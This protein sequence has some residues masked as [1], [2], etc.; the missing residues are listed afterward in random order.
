MNYFSF[1]FKLVILG[2]SQLG[3]M[4]RLIFENSTHKLTF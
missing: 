4:M 1:D 3:K 2:G